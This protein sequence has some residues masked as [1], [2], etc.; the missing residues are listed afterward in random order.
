MW[1][2]IRVAS[3]FALATILTACFQSRGI[4]G[5]LTL[6]ADFFVAVGLALV[7]RI[8][9]VG[10]AGFVIQRALGLAMLLAGIVFRRSFSV[11][12]GERQHAESQGGPECELAQLHRN[13]PGPFSS[14][15]HGGQE[16]ST[17][18]RGEVTQ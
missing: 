6:A 5:F 4:H 12:G 17:V 13:H 11:R 1:L 8:R 2:G 16:R 10:L 7:N 9:G 3:V 18:L 14:D 15:S